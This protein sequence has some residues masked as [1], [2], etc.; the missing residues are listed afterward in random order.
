VIS[1]TKIKKNKI[2]L[3]EDMEFDEENLYYGEKEES[4]YETLGILTDDM[5]GTINLFT[6]EEDLGLYG[7]N[8]LYYSQ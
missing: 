5:S 1:R 2:K 8:V 3:K 4:T 7:E 6:V